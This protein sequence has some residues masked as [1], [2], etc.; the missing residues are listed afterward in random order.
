MENTEKDIMIP[1]DA[2]VGIGRMKIA[3]YGSRDYSYEGKKD[4]QSRLQVSI[5]PPEPRQS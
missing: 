5:S 1:Q 2:G 4:G 3:R